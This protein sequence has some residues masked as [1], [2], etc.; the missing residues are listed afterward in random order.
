MPGNLADTLGVAALV[1]CL[2][3]SLS[4]EID[5]GA[6][7]HDCHPMMVR[8]NKWRAARYGNQATIVDLYSYRVGTVG[9]EVERLAQS[10]AATATD[11]RADGYLNRAVQLAQSTSWAQRQREILS[12]TDDPTEVVR[13]LTVQSRITPPVGVQ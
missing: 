2:V 7:Q 9:A 4:D 11:L 10:I 8:Q 3:K 5:Q 6:Y 1:Q 12:E 13:Q